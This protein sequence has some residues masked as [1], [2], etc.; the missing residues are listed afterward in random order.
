MQ[1]WIELSQAGYWVF[2]TRNRQKFPT[3]L[4]GKKWD[5][6]I[7]EKDQELLHAHLLQGNGTG[8]A[9]CPQPGDATQL[10]ILDMDTYGVNLDDLWAK[11]APGTALDK[12]YSVVGSPSGGFHLWFKLPAGVN[13]NQLPATFDFGDGVAGEVRT[14]SKAKRL[15]MLPDSLATN[16]GGRPAK[17]RIIQGSLTP[18]K[19]QEPPEA[20]MSRLVARRDQGKAE[21]RSQPTEVLHFINLLEDL[22]DVP[23]GRRNSFVAMAG[24]VMGRLHPG[25]QLPPE[26]LD[27]LWNQVA[28][29]LGGDFPEKE[30][31]VSV[32]SGWV[33]GSKNAEKYQAREKNPTVT[34]IRAECEGVF[35]GIPWLVEIRDSTGKTKEFMVGFGGSAKRRHEATRIT[36]LRDLKDI[37]PTLTRLSGAAMDTVAR[38]P[39]FVQPGWAK[40][41]E[42]MLSTEKAVDQLGIP[43]EERFWELLEEWARISAGDLVFLEA[44]TEKRPPGAVSAFLVWP[45]NEDQ[46][47]SLV[48]PPLLQETMLTQIGD[49]PKAKKLVNKYMLQKTLVGMRSGQKVWT[50]PLSQLQ[51]ET[52]EYIGGQYELFVRKKEEREN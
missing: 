30:F 3:S 15:I 36:H 34:D 6:F 5:E 7:E 48:L 43:P 40:V 50:C 49:I 4:A 9:L 35:S 45:M 10:L 17:Y 51:P 47:A 18:S 19:L 14:S 2:P 42:Y 41:L 52:Q 44:W 28:P 11:I 12:S 25:K 39:L 13:A 21:E 27:Q 32:S 22:G 46:V 31:R 24:Q 29:K 38:S 37:L 23:E 20:L 8:A 33:T 16:K 1:L 26:L